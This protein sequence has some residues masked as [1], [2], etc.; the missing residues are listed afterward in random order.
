MNFRFRKRHCR[1]AV[2]HCLA[3]LAGVSTV[4]LM[5]VAAQ[6]VCTES[7]TTATCT[8][9]L[10]SI[11]EYGTD[12]SIDTIDI[13]SLT[14]DFEIDGGS[15]VKLTDN[16][17]TAS[18]AGDAGGNGK[19]LSVTF[20]GGDYGIVGIADEGITQ[21]GFD[22][23]SSGG[24]G[25]TGQEENDT[26][27][28][29]GTGGIGGEAGDVSL[30]MTGGF[31]SQTL[32]HDSAAAISVL[33]EGGT[34]GEGGRSR[35]GNQDVDERTITAGS[36]GE[37]GLA[38]N[39]TVVL[40]DLSNPDS[41]FGFEVA[42]VAYGI[43]ILSVGGDGGQGGEAFCD[44]KFTGGNDYKPCY[45]QSGEGGD[46]T[47]GQKAT[48]GIMGTDLSITDFTSAGIIITSQGGAGG[49]GG[50]A[51][52]KYNAWA[53]NDGDYGRGGDGGVSGAAT[54]LSLDGSSATITE[55]DSQASYGIIVSSLAGA[56]GAGSDLEGE[57]CDTGSGYCRPGFGDGGD[58]GGA[59]IASIGL[60]DSDLTVSVTKDDAVAI[61]IES[62]G[63]DGGSIGTESGTDD[64]HVDDRVDTTANGGNA[65]GAGRVTLDMDSDSTLTVSTSGAGGGY[66]ALTLQ[67]KGGAGGDGA[68]DTFYG[69]TSSGGD[70]G[71]GNEVQ[72]TVYGTVTATTSGDDAYGLLFASL[73]GAG[74]T[75]Y[76]T[77]G[78]G[79]DGDSVEVTLSDVNITTTGKDAYGI[80]A[81]SLGGDGGDSS[82]GGND[83]DGGE[84]MLEVDGGTIDVSGDSAIGIYAI[85]EALSGGSGSAGTGADV[86]V[87]SGADITASGTDNIGIYLKSYGDA[88]YGDL[89]LTIESG[90][91]V[92][93]S[94]SGSKAVVFQNGNNN[95]L[96]N[97]GTITTDDLSSSSKY[98]LHSSTN[99]VDV[100]NNGTFGGSV[101]LPDG[102]DNSFV[103]N[104][105]GTLETG[106]SFDLG[107][108]GSLTSFGTL[109]PGGSG[110]V[111]TST[112][113]GTF[114]QSASG[115]YL[116]DLDAGATD[117]LVFETAG[118]VLDG[119]VSINIV[120][121]STAN[122]SSVIAQSE[123]GDITSGLAATNTATASY[124]V[125]TGS[126]DEIT[127]AWNISPASDGV[128]AS[129]N[130]NQKAVAKHLQ[131]VLQ[132]GGLGPEFAGL[133]NIKSADEYVAALDTL[134][135]QAASDTQMATLSSGARFTDAML[136]CSVRDGTYRFVSQD[137]CVWMRIGGYGVQGSESAASRSYTQRAWQFAGG[138]QVEV[139]DDWFAGAGFSVETQS[140]HVD[141]IAYSEG[142]FY[143]GGLVGKHTIGNTM[144]SA[145]LDAGYG[146]FDI[147]RYIYSGA[148]A[149]G[150]QRLWTL[151]G[152][153][154]ASHAFVAGNWYLKP[155]VDLGFERVALNGFTERGAGGANLTISPSTQTYYNVQPAI[156]FGG[157][158][159]AAGGLLIRPKLSFGLTQYLGDAQP[160]TTASFADTPDGVAPFTITS[161]F[162][163]TYFDVEAGVEVLGTDDVT[164]S[165]Q[166]F[167]QLSRNTSAY[168]ASGKLAVRF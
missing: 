31:L 112:I 119:T 107:S 32:Y 133:L 94:G 113:T 61:F 85:S 65:G 70:G 142:D 75:G 44:N 90:G 155:R 102:V 16:G 9:D 111:L 42:N 136:S 29:A 73:G 109:S 129:A 38:Y 124:T 138:G 56:G 134:V 15:A 4:V 103:N 100:F 74:G 84:V 3:F 81:V 82:S 120:S 157:E 10:D 147:T 118:A 93:A 36:G 92:T 12:D 58:G 154:S 60:S 59:F 63:G 166:G 104:T 13:E 97:N 86:T 18:D 163:K 37:G 110:S 78:D 99:E 45:A 25:A 46:A 55:S 50:L 2:I 101:S 7:G 67:R 69:A 115:T 127:L 79:G 35:Q 121:A 158:I 122:G 168:G 33:S 48:L 167:S 123:D 27:T 80:Y 105:G 14:S 143:Q 40:E 68:S 71:D 23:K 62:I 20:D 51:R 64:W 161:E 117:K 43:S 164:V 108:G 146:S 8:G 98:A 153:L 149:F 77:D 128:L 28:V 95:K 54:A 151:S 131:H 66:G 162:D 72:A 139:E 165:A 135:S 57:T 6:A 141:D 148:V 96:I 91:S 21:Y 150:D 17:G 22:I 137:Q 26:D 145:V 160:S 11:I 152:Q 76:E 41:S 34:G 140:Q 19:D 87:T 116:V 39:A 24:D 132:S 126:S 114:S 83:G 159:R 89:S 130:G 125:T 106:A 47:V 1:G 5:P 88:G 49:K 156:E 53:Q 30:E 52:V 144:L